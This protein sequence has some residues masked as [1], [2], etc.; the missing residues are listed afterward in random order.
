MSNGPWVNKRPELLKFSLLPINQQLHNLDE[1]DDNAI[2]KRGQDLSNKA[3]KILAFASYVN[4]PG[5]LAIHLHLL[6]A[7]RRYAS[8]TFS[9]N[10]STVSPCE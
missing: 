2:S 5:L 9:I 6:P 10:S 8:R 1:W 7:R 3:L 4:T